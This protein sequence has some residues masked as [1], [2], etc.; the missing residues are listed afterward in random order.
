MI[1]F[2]RKKKA[3][4]TSGMTTGPPGQGR[5]AMR[6]VFRRPGPGPRPAPGPAPAPAQT[7]V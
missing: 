6:R 1:I 5:P 2:M 7:T 4:Q 3:G